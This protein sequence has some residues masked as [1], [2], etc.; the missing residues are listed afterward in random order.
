MTIFCPNPNATSTQ[1]TLSW[2]RVE[3]SAYN[4][5]PKFIMTQKNFEPKMD[6]RKS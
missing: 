4:L 2:V 3:N 5:G 6:E 1:S